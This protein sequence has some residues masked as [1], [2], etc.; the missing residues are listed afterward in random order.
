MSSTLSRTQSEFSTRRWAAEPS[1]DAPLHPADLDLLSRKRPSFAKRTSRTLS[2]LLVTFL[3]GVG[4]TLGWQSYGDTTREIIASSSP[5]LAWLAPQVA[6]VGPTALAVPSPDQEELKSV[7]FGLAEVRQRVDQIAAQL[8]AGREQ[9]TRDI[10]RLQAVEQDILD[11]ISAP[12]PAPAA[13]PVRRPAT[14]TAP[15]AR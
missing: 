15:A 14:L 2:R 8:A 3:V 4:A 13:A 9:M 7:S 6:S 1:I 11:K 10:N 5:A 12:A